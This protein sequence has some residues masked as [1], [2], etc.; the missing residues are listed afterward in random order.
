MDAI[1]TTTTDDTVADRTETHFRSSN[2]S[3]AVLNSIETIDLTISLSF[4]TLASEIPLTSD[5]LRTVACAIYQPQQQQQQISK[6]YSLP[7]TFVFCDQ[8]LLHSPIPPYGSRHFEVSE[9]HW[10]Q[11]HALAR[12]RGSGTGQPVVEE[13]K[14][15]EPRIIWYICYAATT[16][17][18]LHFLV[19]LI[20]LLLWISM[21]RG[22]FYLHHLDNYRVRKSNRR[23]EQELYKK[24]ETRSISFYCEWLVKCIVFAKCDDSSGLLFLA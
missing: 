2:A 3:A 21:G 19:L 8:L 12:L 9:C 15:N 17:T 1:T 16:T 10:P 14:C 5:N 4:A 6:V 20:D 7:P 11:C 22:F 13:R 23:M 24:S 18:H